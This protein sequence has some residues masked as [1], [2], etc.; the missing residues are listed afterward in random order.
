MF[1][2]LSLPKFM[3][4]FYQEKWIPQIISICARR[5]IN[6]LYIIELALIVN[7]EISKK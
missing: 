1:F 2:K 4:S 7:L 5:K 3:R 6:R